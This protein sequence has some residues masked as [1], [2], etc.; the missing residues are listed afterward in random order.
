M[1]AAD[2]TPE[3]P[4]APLPMQT[5]KLP[6][7]DQTTA[8]QV[9]TLLQAVQAL[10]HLV[11]ARCGAVTE[12]RGGPDD[13]GVCSALDSSIIRAL[14]QLDG[15]FDDA[16]RWTLTLQSTL[17]KQLSDV[18]TAHLELLRLQKQ[19]VID[20]G[21]PHRTAGP[22]LLQLEGGDWAAIL[23]DPKHLD[24]CLLGVGDSPA[25]A[26][27]DFDKVFNGAKNNEQK[28]NKVDGG[29]NSSGESPSRNGTDLRADRPEAGPD[30]GVS[31][32]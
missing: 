6:S 24:N 10:N 3:P 5:I 1:N 11:V 16:P 20:I 18:Y 7:R 8:T 26:L 9:N 17:E 29:G 19:A 12:A 31:P 30:S 4:D 23:G 22:K 15:I 27:A 32:A 13:G 25:A 21:L 28:P 2:E 14:N